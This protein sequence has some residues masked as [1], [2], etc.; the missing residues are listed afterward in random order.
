[1]NFLPD[2]YVPCGECEGRRFNA[3]TL[4]VT[5]R[6]KTIADILEMTVE[7]AVAFFEFSRKIGLPLK[8]M[9]E[10][11]LGYL[12][13]GQSSPTLSGGEAQRLKLVSELMRGNPETQATFFEKSPSKRN[14]Y[15][16]EEP[17]IGLHFSDV[18]K[19]IEMLHRLVDLGHTV[20]VIEHQLDL[21]A[22]ADYLLDLGPGGGDEGGQMVVAGAPEEVAAARESRTAPFLK[23]VLNV[24]ARARGH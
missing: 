10:T 12:A 16:L 2:T 8:L 9:N 19:L 18:E 20:V 14:L 11:G 24:N 5:Y 13:L 4:E 1:M 23:R 15:L 7:E 3:E 22:E 17:T 6:E 21:L